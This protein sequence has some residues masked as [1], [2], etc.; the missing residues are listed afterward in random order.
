MKHIHFFQIFSQVFTL[1]GTQDTQRQANQRPQ[2]HR[3]PGMVAHVGEI[4]H[5][6]VTVVT[7][8]DTVIRTRIQNLFGLEAAVFPSCIGVTG[9]QKTAAAAATVIVGAVGLHIDKV[10]FTHHGFDHIAQIFGHRIA[11]RLAHQL[12]GIL[13]GKLYT[14][15]FVPIGIDLQLAFPDPLGIVL[16]DAFDFE[17]VGEV[18]FLRSE[19]DR[20]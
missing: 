17:V 9:L 1:I 7:R 12:T 2:V 5:L 11:K 18:E 4:V 3:A 15:I 19:P 16:N 13:H 8:G 6:R 14:A 20:E 10:F